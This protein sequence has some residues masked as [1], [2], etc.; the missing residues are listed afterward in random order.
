M[1]HR[2]NELII[3]TVRW[4]QRCSSEITAAGG[5]AVSILDMIS[6]QLLVHLVRN[7]LY[8]K[9]GP[10]KVS[11][12][13]TGSTSKNIVYNTVGAVGADYKEAPDEYG[14]GAVGGIGPITTF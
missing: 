13:S 7:D 6:P 11:S 4:V 8:L 2:E 9:H 5:S 12:S 14:S 3:K 1:I 10:S